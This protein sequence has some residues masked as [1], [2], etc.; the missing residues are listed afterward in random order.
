MSRVLAVLGLVGLA[1]AVVII[2]ALFDEAERV[3]LAELDGRIA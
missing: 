1:A 3:R 2:F